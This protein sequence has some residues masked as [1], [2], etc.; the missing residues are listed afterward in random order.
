MI[1]FRSCNLAPDSHGKPKANVA[2]FGFIIIDKLN[3]LKTY[4]NNKYVY[5]ISL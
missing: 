1:F 2:S 4:F 5:I 3:A